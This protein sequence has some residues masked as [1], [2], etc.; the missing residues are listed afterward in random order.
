M[1]DVRTRVARARRRRR[2]RSGWRWSPSIRIA[3]RRCS[4]TTSAASSRWPRARH[5]RRGRTARRRR[6]V[7]CQLPRRGERRR[8][9]R[10]H[11]H[12][13]ALRRRRRRPARPDLAV[14]SHRRRPRR[15][16]RTAPRER[17]TGPGRR[18]ARLV[19]MVV[20]RR[21]SIGVFLAV[22]AGVVVASPSAA[23]ADSAATHRL[24]LRG[25]RHRSTDT[26]DRGVDRRWRR[27]RPVAGGSRGRG[28]GH[29]LPERAVSALRRRR[30][31]VREPEL[32][33]HVHQRIPLRRQLDSGGCI[34]RRRA[35]LG[36]G[37]AAGERRVRLARP[38]FPPDGA[39]RAGRG[40]T[41]R[42][43]LHRC[44][45][46]RRRRG[47]RERSDREHVDARSV[48]MA[49]GARRGVRRDRGR[50]G[51]RRADPR[52]S[53]GRSSSAWVGSRR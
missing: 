25:G 1:S 46:D 2:R 4:P 29:G 28:R 10:G 9:D 26:I 22:V 32:A 44:G 23:I 31:G 6:S 19:P 15:R 17:M 49:C 50:G 43:G 20:T 53:G 45:A 21:H 5:R 11:P 48:A 14:R 30:H 7:R 38:P 40:A 8:R 35:G 47:C 52:A 34:G 27:V 42:P 37:R 51:L 3:T 18:L 36:R 33:G 16:P 24:P 41:G 12:H 39:D 13:A